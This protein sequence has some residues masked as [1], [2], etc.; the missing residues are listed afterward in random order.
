MQVLCKS[1]N[2]GAEIHCNVCGQGFALFW[3]R[4]TKMEKAQALHEIDKALRKHH[5]NQP[6]PEAHPVRG[7]LVPEWEGQVSASGAA[8]LGNAPIWSL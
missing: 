8:I 5:Y 6:G 4:P 1:C 7:F 3:E 2:E